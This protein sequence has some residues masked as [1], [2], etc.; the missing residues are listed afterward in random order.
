[1]IFHIHSYF[2]LR[3]G[4]LAPEDIMA[5]AGRERMGLVLGDINN[6]SAA[7][8]W[9]KAASEQSEARAHVGV[10]IKNGAQDLYLLIS[11]SQTG[12]AAINRFVSDYLLNEKPFPV[13]P[14]KLKDCDAL[15]FFKDWHKQDPGSLPM[16]AWVAV[17][18]EDL[19]RLRL[20]PWK[21][22]SE[23]LLAYKLMRL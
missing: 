23:R 18:A 20:S 22:E 3:Y 19:P 2:S 7:C 8:N 10:H 21:R 16:H 4:L 9:L 14:P 13:H 12:F 11:R 15:V 6:A 1:M 17:R 5:W